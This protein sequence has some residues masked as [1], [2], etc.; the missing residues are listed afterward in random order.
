LPEQTVHGENDNHAFVQSAINI[1]RE[2]G[3]SAYI[4]GEHRWSAVH[5]LDAAQL[6]R[7]ALENGPAG[8]IYHAVAEEGVPTQEVAE[9]IGRH[10]H[11]PIVS[12]S[13]EEAQA[14]FGFFALLIGVDNPASGKLTQEKLGWHPSH[15]GLIAD[16]EQGHY[17]RN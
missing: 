7:L 11:L 1:A 4:E 13:A 10:L 12:M 5:K 17:F 14:H 16:I 2:K 6:Y 8:S 15:P 9:A 3:V